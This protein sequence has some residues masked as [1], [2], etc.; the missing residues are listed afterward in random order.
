MQGSNLTARLPALA[1]LVVTG[2]LVVYFSAR[3]SGP[4]GGLLAAVGIACAGALAL[5]PLPAE[6]EGQSAPR[7]LDSAGRVLDGAL[8]ALPGALTVYLAFDA[9]GYFP[10][11]PALAG[12]ALALVLVLRLALVERPFAGFSPPAAVAAG[13]LGLYALWTLLSATWSDASARSLLEFDR[14]L[15]YC[16]ALVVFGSM[17]RSFSRLRWMAG[18]LSVGI[19][20]IA[21]VA[22]ATWILPETFP[23]EATRDHRSLSYPLT[24]SNALGILCVIGAILSL[25]FASSLR[26][27]RWIRAL[28]A[29]ALPI[30]AVTVYFTMSRGP[31][32]VAVV[33][34]VIYAVLGRPRGLLTGLLA[35]VPASIVAV[36][37]A[38]ESDLLT[39]KGHTTAAAVAQGKELAVAVGVCALAAAGLRLLLAPLD[40]RVRKFSLPTPL[41]DPVTGLA[42]VAGIAGAVTLAL[43]SGT[44]GWIEE[45]YDRFLHHEQGTPGADGRTNLADASNHGRVDNWDVALGAFRDQPFHGQGAGTY[46]L[47]WRAE[48]PASQV[49]YDVKD[50]HSLY[51]EVLSELGI[52]GLLLLLTA[53]VAVFLALAPA[54]RGIERSLYAALFAAAV[55]WAVHAGVDWDWE[56]PAVSLWLFAIGG[57]ALATHRRRIARGPLPSVAR[58][59]AGLLV[60]ALAFVP[61][62]I[63]ASERQLQAAADAYERG[64]CSEGAERAK[65]SSATLG[66][67]PEPYELLAYCEV[68]RGRARTGLRA[69]R[70]AVER[71]P[72]NWKFHY[73]L[74]LVSGAAGLDPRPA[75]HEARRLNPNFRL[76]EELVREFD[77]GTDRDRKRLATR[78]ARREGLYVVR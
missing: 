19:V 40:T 78:L 16:L 24:Y 5:R 68:R 60:L 65:A 66:T 2:C 55:T 44:P 18:G 58:L 15:V 59:V 57:A 63:L 43:V 7:A 38:Y 9:G 3:A 4:L 32:F 1:V 69:M 36:L 6:V 37:M 47:T 8:L 31:V 28:A 61:G 12:I 52:V 64:D 27:N 42:W 54:W 41:R 70:K 62:L 46:E 75:A 26:E 34:L 72:A 35:T 17:P 71:D 50:A 33:G 21:L 73:G 13:A 45:R 48:R 76:T 74:A 77:R 39:G 10:D 11:G 23:V 20:V 29:G 14:A 25:H 22:L 30:L 53:L 56:I 49:T 67:R 51:V